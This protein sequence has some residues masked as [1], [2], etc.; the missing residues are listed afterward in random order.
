[1]QVSPS[2]SSLVLPL[3]NFGKF[4]SLQGLLILLV[5]LIRFEG[6]KFLLGISLFFVFGRLEVEV[7][8]EDAE[9]AI[10]LVHFH[11]VDI[12]CLN[13]YRFPLYRLQFD[14]PPISEL[15]LPG[16]VLYGVS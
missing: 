13:F 6:Y 7:V 8:A 2:F 5:R 14:F 9:I 1:M 15:L 11:C 16:V 4:T 10:H 12:F 3:V